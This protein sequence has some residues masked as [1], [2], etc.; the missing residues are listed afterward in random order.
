MEQPPSNELTRAL[1][2]LGRG[3]PDAAEELWQLVY[4]ELH[5]LARRR[6]SEEPAGQ[7]L[8]PTALV[9]EVYLRLLG[10]SADWQCRAHFFAAA[11]RAMRNIVID[12]VRARDALKRGGDRERLALSEGIA[13]VDDSSVDLLDL[14][15]A[16]RKL[17]AIDQ[18]KAAIVTLRYLLG[19]T[20]EETAQALSISTA[21]VKQD[22]TFAKAWLQR[23]LR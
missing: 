5:E 9:H 3:D 11:A 10:D 15:A 23:E 22:W 14:D 6:M 18:A 1:A 21:K 2:A 12:R 8:Q 16:L 13:A 17:E 20:V 7:T 19:C 4:N